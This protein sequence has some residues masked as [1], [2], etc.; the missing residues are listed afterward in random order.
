MNP[1][2]HKYGLSQSVG[3]GPAP[4]ALCLRVA[5]VAWVYCESL[6]GGGGWGACN[7][8][9]FLLDVWRAFDFAALWDPF[10][11]RVGFRAIS[12][13]WGVLDS[14]DMGVLCVALGA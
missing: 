5:G 12:A 4:P 10:V 6:G 14:L 2:K 9:V 3:W 7:G 11:K 1:L 13:V 8:L